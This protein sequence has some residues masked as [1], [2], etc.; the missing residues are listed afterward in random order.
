MRVIIN[1]LL[2]VF[3]I[4]FV[5]L[6]PVAMPVAAQTPEPPAVAPAVDIE[7]V[8]A[9]LED[10]LAREQ[11]IAK[12][13]LLAEANAPAAAPAEVQAATAQLLQGVSQQLGTFQE[14]ALTIAEGLEDIPQ[15]LSWAER[16]VMNP[17]ERQVWIEVLTNLAIVLGLGYGAYVLARWLLSRPRR[18]LTQRP[19]G[20]VLARSLLLTVVLLLDV[21]QIAAFLAVTYLSLSLI[22]PREQ[23]RLVALAW[24]HAAL[25]VRLV[26]A[27][28]RWVFAPQTPGLRLPTLSDA[29]AQYGIVWLRRLTFTP[30]YGYFGLQAGLLLGLP[31]LAYESLL[32]LLGLIVTGMV[33]VLIGQNRSTV[34]ALIRGRR[35]LASGRRPRFATLRHRLAQVWHLLAL[36][37]VLVLYG[38]W[39]LEVRDGFLFLPKATALTVLLVLLGHFGAQVLAQMFERGLH[40]A[41]AVKADYPGLEKRLNRYL[42]VLHAGL[43]GLLYLLIGLALCQVWGADVLGWL[44]SEAG[45]VLTGTLLAVTGIVLF[46]VAVW[47]IAGTLIENYLA[48]RDRYGRLRIRSARTR[49]LLSVSRNALFIFLIIVGTLLVLSELGINIA[50]LVAGAGVLGVALGFGSQKLVQDVITGVFILFE[51]LISV[52]DVVDVGGKGGVVEAVSICNVRLRDLSGT[53]HTIPYSAITTV[54]NLTKDFSYYVFDVGIAYQENVDE[55]I[56]V[57]KALGAEMQADGH[58]GALILEPLE[59]LGL[60]AFAD[61]AVVIK[62]RI[63]TLPIQQWNVGREFNRRLKQRFDD[64][65]IEMPF[66]HRT[67]YF[68]ELKQGVTPPG[69]VQLEKNISA[70]SGPRN[71]DWPALLSRA[72]VQ[73]RG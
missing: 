37:Y 33:I 6:L 47:E 12:L 17:V 62:A 42:P 10:P 69:R 19:P 39:A 58:Y 36:L 64:L 41:P 7:A 71:V 18:L 48:E 20:S 73:A 54:S 23:T 72:A 59:V 28:G 44:S 15:V 24:I 22:D 68:G 57:L 21:L 51:D 49:T 5:L 32:R 14:A 43:R 46:T 9:D 70:E 34:G 29:S 38:V 56:D 2:F 8:I 50:P 1:N 40:L 25:I 4:F 65:G 13:K 27:A 55:V 61:S 66:P 16:Q 60:D 35:D 63:K 26:L 52:G 11:L 67:L 3:V 30:V 31:W 45:R 53:V